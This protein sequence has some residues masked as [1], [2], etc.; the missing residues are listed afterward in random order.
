MVRIVRGYKRIFMV[1]VPRSRS[2]C[3]TRALDETKEFSVFHEPFVSV[4]GKKV[5]SELTS[6]WF[7][8]SSFFSAD[9]VLATI[10]SV[11]KDVLV[12][13]MSFAI[14]PHLGEIRRQIPEAQFILLYRLPGQ[15]IA[16][17]V[18]KWN[19]LGVPMAPATFQDIIGYDQLKQIHGDITQNPSLLPEQQVMVTN[20]EDVLSAAEDIFRF[21]DMPLPESITWPALTCFAAAEQKAILWHEQKSTQM[22]QDW[23]RE[24]L[25]STGFQNTQSPLKRVYRYFEHLSRPYF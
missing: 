7:R 22:F 13:D 10:R 24:A 25:E 12:K 5:Y 19:E 11:R 23:H 15:A 4:Y 9:D 20:T 2:V 1:G 8:P 18:A 14:W 16:S 3:L 6:N 21:L 17:L